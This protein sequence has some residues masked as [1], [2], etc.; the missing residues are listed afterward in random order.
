MLSQCRSTSELGHGLDYLLLDLEK[1]LPDSLEELQD[2]HIE[3]V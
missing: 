3:V 2:L 1:N